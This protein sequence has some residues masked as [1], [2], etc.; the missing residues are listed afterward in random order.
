MGCL[1]GVFKVLFTIVKVAFTLLFNFLKWCFTSGWKGIMVIGTICVLLV[2]IIIVVHTNTGTG[3]KDKN[4]ITSAAA[5]TVAQAPYII[6]TSSR[7]YYAAK[8]ETKDG[9]TTMTGYWELTGKTWK[10]NKGTLVLT[11]EFGTVTV[12]KRNQ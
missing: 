9:I 4:T 8:A 3:I 5:P 1:V 6:Q 2:L 12:G 7:Y 11:K 10:Y